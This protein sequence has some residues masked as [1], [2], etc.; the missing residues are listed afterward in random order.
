MR[1]HAPKHAR[2]SASLT[3][4]GCGAGLVNVRMTPEALALYMRAHG[5]LVTKQR[6]LCSACM[7][8]GTA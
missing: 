1:A 7:P 3:C 5:W 6:V 8:R 4:Q 2:P